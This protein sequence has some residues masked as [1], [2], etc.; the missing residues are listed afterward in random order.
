MWL[1]YL[2]AVNKLREPGG[3]QAFR[4][5]VLS[6]HASAYFGESTEGNGEGD[7][8]GVTRCSEGFFGG[9][10]VSVLAGCAGFDFDKLCAPSSWLGWFV[11]CVD[12]V[13]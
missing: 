7:F 11:C 1:P 8:K 10:A 13:G 3:K 4:N 5:V 2:R 6:R 9:M 12:V